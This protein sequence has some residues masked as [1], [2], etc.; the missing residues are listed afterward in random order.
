MA[1]GSVYDY[2]L[3][4]GSTRYMAVYRTS[5][6]VQ[7]KKK[8]FRG[9]REAERFLNKTMADVDAGRLIATRDTFAAYID[10]WLLE[11]RPRI[12]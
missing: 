4:D 10:R 3:A 8:G 6:G 1:K 9:V 7:R 5:N 11:H 12:E 2:E